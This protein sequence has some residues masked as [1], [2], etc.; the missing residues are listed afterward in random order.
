MPEKCRRMLGGV[1]QNDRKGTRMLRLV[2]QNAGEIK[3]WRWVSPNARRRKKIL[4][5]VN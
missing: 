2:N 3:M 1:N 4:R 5:W